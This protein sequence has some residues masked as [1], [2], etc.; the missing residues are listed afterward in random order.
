MAVIGTAV[1]RKEDPRLLRGRGAF[2]DGF[3]A[4]GELWA[5]IVRSP[6]AHGTV[7]TVDVT[8]ARQA[9]GVAAAVTAAELPPGLAIPIRLALRG[10]PLTDYLQP[11]LAAGVVRYVGEPLAVVVAGDAYAA[12]DAAELVDLDIEP[13]PAVLDAAAAAG[14][15][16]PRLFP[17]GNVAADVTLDYGDPEA[18]FARAAHVAETE[19]EIGRHTAVPLEPRALLAE[20]DPRTGGL[21]ITGMTKVPVFNRDVLAAMLG[22]D[23]T[24]IHVRA[25][26]AGGGFGV[27]GEFYPE[28]YLVPWLARTLGRPVKWAEDRA[29]H[30][31]AVNHSR[32]QVHRIRGAFDGN[33]RILAL[34]D[35]ILH[36]NGA[37]CRT[38]GITV[39]ELTVA[40]L[41]GPYR[42]P[43]FRGRIR[44]LLT[45]K[46]PCGTYRAPGRF[47]GT[48][49]REQLLDMAADQL[50]I[51]RAELRRRNLLRPDELPCRRP[52]TTLGTDVVL[53]TGDYP[54]LLAAAEAEA[55][56]LGY[57]AL[58]AQGREA[59]RRRGLGLAVF[60]EKSGL[61]PQETADVMV[62]KTGTVHV[63]S[64][65]TSLGQGIETVLAQIAADALGIG[66]DM[67]RVV[68]GDTALQP[69]GSGSWASRTTVVAGNAVHAAAAAV[70]G[71]A[72]QLAAR[73]LE[74]AEDDLVAADGMIAVRGDPRSAVRLAQIA[75]A[76]APAGGHLRPG[77]PAGL[78]ARR[79]FDVTHMTYPYGVHIA[80]AEVDPGTGEVRVLRYLVAYE[81]G[82]AVNPVLVEGQLRGGVAQG[83]GGSLLEEFSYDETGQPQAVTFMDYRMPT[84]AE[85]PPIDVLV[86]Q[87]ARSPGN[88]LGV[89]GAGEGG[90]SAAGAALASAV[91]DALGLAGSV[92][93]LPLTPVRVTALTGAT[94]RPENRR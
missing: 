67:V 61:G 39:P 86:T 5:R 53:D 82:R 75:G 26:D 69:Y 30:L 32:Q 80:V 89:M 25:I 90:I 63:H 58:V 83:I 77:E 84:A 85:V 50:G 15:G 91:R 76:A 66:M 81:V 62:S 14:D 54:A 38:H 17:A 71:R 87:Q 79:R 10:L 20:P 31:V 60:L 40:M 70:A 2:T 68:N 7:R 56:R 43:A 27:R 22:I 35:D 94:P 46:T 28:D 13:L 45:N 41:P 72:R 33:G 93:R 48:T 37:Y 73:M 9:R 49:A 57:Q 88:P 52:L 29:E 64:G 74:A 23:E 51:G 16:S 55:A 34:A 44:V 3:H 24:L 78:A 4:R 59:G 11:V 18:A 8:R 1:P 47:E 21:S 42:V 36:D 6:V 92:G 65:G 19:I 12:E